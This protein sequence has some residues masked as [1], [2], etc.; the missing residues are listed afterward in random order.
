MWPLVACTT[1]EK[2]NTM[3]Y[4]DPWVVRGDDKSGIHYENRE[5]IPFFAVSDCIQR[6]VVCNFDVILHNNL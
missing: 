4:Y 1:V 6:D 2:N 5:D 3:Y